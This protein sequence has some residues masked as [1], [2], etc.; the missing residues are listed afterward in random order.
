MTTSTVRKPVD[1]QKFSAIP[2]VNF[3]GNAQATQAFSA[4][5]DMYDRRFGPASPIAERAVVWGDL[6]DIGLVA[7]RNKNGQMVAKP[8]AAGNKGQATP[9]RSP[10]TDAGQTPVASGRYEF[11]APGIAQWFSANT[12]PTTLGD[13]GAQF[14]GS[15]IIACNY[16][17]IAPVSASVGYSYGARVTASATALA[18]APPDNTLICRWFLCPSVTVIDAVLTN[19][20]TITE[21]TDKL[22]MIKVD[23]WIDI[24][25]MGLTSAELL[26]VDWQLIRLA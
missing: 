17:E 15:F 23:A 10:V 1:R 16:R 25:H 13:A 26:A 3:P 19:A 9:I 6:S 8:Q 2:S 7:L 21:N 24:Q 4:L 20:S 14:V 18:P 11:D 22:V 12:Y 5:G